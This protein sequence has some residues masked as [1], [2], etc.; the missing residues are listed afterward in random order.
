MPVLESGVGIFH[1]YK[2][3]GKFYETQ[4]NVILWLKTKVYIVSS[5]TSVFILCAAP[6]PSAARVS[7]IYMPRAVLTPVT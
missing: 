2:E 5:H 1:H 7:P 3:G 6:S 4:F